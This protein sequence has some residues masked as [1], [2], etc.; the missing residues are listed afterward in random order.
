M[1]ITSFA[2]LLLY[3]LK[4]IIWD[5]FIVPS[6]DGPIL[7]AGHASSANNYKLFTTR[8]KL[9]GVAHGLTLAEIRFHF[10]KVG[11]GC[12]ELRMCNSA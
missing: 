12:P 7:F 11:D 8:F 6:S 10:F 1:R 9:T 5:A 3:G 4:S 2:K